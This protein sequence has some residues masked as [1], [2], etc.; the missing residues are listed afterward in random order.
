VL[1]NGRI[2]VPQFNTNRIVEFDS[3]GRIVWEA[4]YQWP[5][6]AVRLPNGNTLVSSQNSNKVAELDRTGKTVWEYQ[7]TNGQPW[8]ARRR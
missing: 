5:T 7:C 2:V 4:P 6:T 3:D 8:R 1:P